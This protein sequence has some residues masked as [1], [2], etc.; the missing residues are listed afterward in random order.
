MSR[1]IIITIPDDFDGH[2]GFV[3]MEEIEWE[4]EEGE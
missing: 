4:E 3:M 2:D 1:K